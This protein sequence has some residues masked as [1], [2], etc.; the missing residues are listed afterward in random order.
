MRIPQNHR[1]S[2]FSISIFGPLFNYCPILRIM[3]HAIK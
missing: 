2:T 1:L 3:F